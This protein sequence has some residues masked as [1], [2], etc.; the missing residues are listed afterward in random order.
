MLLKQALKVVKKNAYKCLEENTFVN[1][2]RLGSGNS[3]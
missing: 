3:I 2:G 1:V